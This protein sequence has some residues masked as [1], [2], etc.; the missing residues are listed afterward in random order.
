MQVA[1]ADTYQNA[2]ER[3][4][5]IAEITEK[6]SV[7]NKLLRLRR[8]DG[9]FIWASETA[10]AHFDTKG[11]I[12]WIDGIIGDITEYKKAEEARR[13]IEGKFKTLVENLNVGVYRNTAGPQGRFL[14]ANPAIARIFGYDSVESFMQVPVADTY[15]NAEER[16]MFIA[17]IMEKGSVR[18]KVLRLHRKD[19]T[20][21]WASLTATAHFDA[22]GDIDW[23]DG[24]L[25]D[26]TERK[27][28]EEELNNSQ[29]RLADIIRVPPGRRDG[30]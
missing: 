15:Q 5:F 12:E 19:G 17:E 13:E 24:I 22:K 14:H 16:K 30:H 26:I 23:M 7:R 25:E 3:K 11:D 18:N 4:M 8:K 6:G 27:H 9:T 21:I 1:V 10:T 20:F 2:E 28:V 29:R